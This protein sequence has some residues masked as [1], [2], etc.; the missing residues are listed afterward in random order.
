[1][2]KRL[3]LN[4]GDDG[5]FSVI[6]SCQETADED[7][8]CEEKRKHG[9][10]GQVVTFEDNNLRFVPENRFGQFDEFFQ[11]FFKQ[12]ATMGL[13]DVN[14]N[15]MMELNISLIETHK[16]IIIKSLEIEKQANERIIESIEEASHH[17][18]KK[19]KKM[20]S[21]PQRLKEY[22]KHELF[23]E[24]KEVSLA[25]KWR[26]K[27]SPGSDLP[28]HDLVPS[29]CQFVSIIQTLKVV[30]SQQDFQSIYVN[31]NQKEKHICRDG[32][33]VD[34]C[35]G[36]T[37]KKSDLFKDKN[38]IQIQLAM[39][40]F[41]VC[42]PVKSKATKHKICGIYFQIR[43]LP[44]NIVSKID[45]IFLVALASSAD[46]KSDNTLNDLNELI[47]DELKIL[48]TK[49]F[50]T[51]DGKTWRGALV[52]MACD[53]LGAN[54]VFGFSKGFN[55]NYYCRLCEMSRDECEITTHELADKLRS[56]ASHEEHIKLVNENPQCTLTESMGVRMACL[57]NTLKNYDMFENVSFDIMHDMHEGIIPFFLTAFFE[58]C[59]EQKIYSE[60]DI[61]RKIRDF[62]YGYTFTK[63]KPS[64]LGMKKTHLGQNASQSY[65]IIVHLPFIF[66]DAKEKLEKYWPLLEALLKCLQIV[67]STSITESDLIHLENNIDTFLDGML[68][69][70]KRLTPKAHF[71]TH[72]PRA[73]RKIG[74][75][76]HFWTMRFE[77]KHKFFTDSAK[78]TNNF[79]NL[80]K[81]LAQKHQQQICL[82]RFSIK[83]DIEE[84]KK[85]E[86]FR[87]HC[88]FG[89]YESFLS[90]VDTN[91]EFDHLFM[92]PFLKINN[93]IYKKG[94]VLIENFLVYDILFVLKTYNDYH[95]L[96]ELYETKKFEYSLNSIEIEPYC[97][98][99]KLVYIKYSELPNLQSFSKN[100]HNGKLYVIAENLS[101]FN[102]F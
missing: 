61:I 47:T 41:E 42:C 55:A 65:C 30:F 76:K 50:E 16:E 94:L 72:Y 6:N 67:M 29:T 18:T 36:S 9:L 21:A 89:K 99:E 97:P 93:Y 37:C 68:T 33:Y 58:Y 87:N 27:T 91:I 53:N 5:T 1:M 66:H 38:V 48:E 100:T 75:L 52:N 78:T 96:C 12:T 24:P 77:S 32:V 22:R 74:P 63:N 64:L 101:V 17:M 45:N 73:I 98:D 69:L 80:K 11:E 4:I 28:V 62:N 92:I 81:T 60:N 95:F 10:K 70:N 85:I 15:K 3:K 90:S 40:D 83:N 19:L 25:L 59:I 102:S 13:T 88:D 46:L 39:D 82:K 34:F 7:G 57:Y 71:L 86:L 26:T 2:A 31:Y 43:N 84:S 44:A 14:I 23:I 8:I 49:G 54:T 20:A 35:C 51:T 56:K 79:I